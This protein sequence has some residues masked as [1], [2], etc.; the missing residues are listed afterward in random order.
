MTY[1]QRVPVCVR[2]H[3]PIS[4]GDHVILVA[5]ELV[6]GLFSP[7]SFCEACMA[8]SLIHGPQRTVNC[9]LTL[10]KAIP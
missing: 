7:E 1:L 3:W 8:N 9:W 2:P 6:L 10:L 5:L 4:G